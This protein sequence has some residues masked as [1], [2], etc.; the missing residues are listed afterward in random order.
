MSKSSIGLL[1]HVVSVVAVLFVGAVAGTS[2]AQ[3]FYHWQDRYRY[4]PRAPE[5]APS[6]AQLPEAPGAATGET[7]VL[8]ESLKGLVFVDH[9]DKVVERRENVSGVLVDGET[10]LDLLRSAAFQRVAESYLGGPVSIRRLNELARDI[11]LLYRNNDQPVVDVSVPDQDISGGVVQIVVTEARAGQVVVEGP[12]WFDPAR[13]VR[14]TCISPGDVIYESVLLEDARWL[15]RNPFRR[16]DLRLRPGDERGLTDVVFQVT[17]R[18][19][20]R[21]YA[22]YEDTGTRATGLERTFY[23]FNWYNALRRDDWFGYQYTASSDFEKLQ[24]HSGYYSTALLNRDVLSVYG[25]YAEVNAATGG[26]LFNTAGITWQALFRWNRQLCP[27]GCWEHGISAGFDFKQTNTNL[28]FGGTQVFASSADIAQFV[29]GY[30]GHRYDDLGGWFLG[31]EAFYSPG[32]LGGNNNN[33]AFQTQRALA[34][35]N[36][37][38]AR[39]FLERRT[40]LVPQVEFVARGNGQIA[41]GNLLQI[42]QLGFGGYN[43]IRGY[44]QYAVLGDSGYFINFELWTAPIYPLCRNDELRMLAFYDFGDAYNHTLLP[45]ED[46]SVD[47]SGV[48]VG[49]RYAI[50]PNFNLRADYGWQTAQIANIPNPRERWHVGA[51]VSY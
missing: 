44:D 6:Q 10:G 26:G 34:T 12:C 7:K 17:D 24:A 41:D 42:E 45:G 27:I 8:I 43:S 33:T 13:L 9:P 19:P 38:Y 31:A 29:V 28:D 51:V 37:A 25:T 4:L 32:G 22:G 16:V 30:Q 48:G 18:M 3:E 20:V 46:P 5:V 11:I 21:V 15:S 36:Y 35:A 50:R 39:G 23:G 49:L 2:Y 14:Q 47:L 40:W 1:T